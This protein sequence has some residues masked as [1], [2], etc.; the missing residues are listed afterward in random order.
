LHFL[1][2][3][4]WGKSASEPWF[5]RAPGRAARAQRQ[6]SDVWKSTLKL[7]ATCAFQPRE[8]FPIRPPLQWANAMHCGNARGDVVGSRSL[9]QLM[10]RTWLMI[11][12]P[13]PA[14]SEA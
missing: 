4:L 2:F 7:A 1:H 9:R 3:L 5:L 6:G 12:L 10:Q 14:W 11:D 13:V 8:H